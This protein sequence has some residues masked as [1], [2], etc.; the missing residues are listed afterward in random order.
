MSSPSLH[1]ICGRCG[2]NDSLFYRIS[3]NV[4]FEG[5]EWPTA[6]IK[7]SNCSTVTDLEEIILKEK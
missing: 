3:L 6:I 1:I 7:C 2:R 5:I 4:D